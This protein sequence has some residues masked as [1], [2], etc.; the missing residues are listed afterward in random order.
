[1]KTSERAMQ[2]FELASELD[3]ANEIIDN[4]RIKRTANHMY[5]RRMLKEIERGIKFRVVMYNILA[6]IVREICEVFVDLKLAISPWLCEQLELLLLDRGTRSVPNCVFNCI[7]VQ[8]CFNDH[9]HVTDGIKSLGDASTKLDML[10]VDVD[11]LH[12]SSGMTCPAADF[13]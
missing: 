5:V 11:S 6:Q 8:L 10:I 9:M 4:W 3:L 13:V 12:S 7:F 2:G 1:M